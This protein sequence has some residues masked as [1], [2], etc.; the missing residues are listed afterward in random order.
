MIL[1]ICAF[2]LQSL[3]FKCGTRSFEWCTQWESNS[4]MK[5]CLCVSVCIVRFIS[6]FLYFP[7]SKNNFEKIL[8]SAPSFR[9]RPFI[10]NSISKKV[11]PYCVSKILKVHHIFL[12]H[13]RTSTE[14]LQFSESFNFEKAKQLG[15]E[16]NKKKICSIK[17][18][19]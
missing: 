13:K 6:L 1:H 19:I 11:I 12:K 18:L 10:T 2:N 9:K 5:F 14:Y 17:R 15:L 7:I 3:L 8:L 16:Q 4:L